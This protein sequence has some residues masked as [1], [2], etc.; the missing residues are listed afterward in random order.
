MLAAAKKTDSYARKDENLY[1][2]AQF[3]LLLG[4]RASISVSGIPL[5]TDDPLRLRG[6]VG[7]VLAGGSVDLSGN[8]LALLGSIISASGASA[9]LSCL[10][11]QL[12]LSG[13]G[14]VRRIR[15]DSA[16]GSIALQG[17]QMLY[18]AAMLSAK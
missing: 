7:T 6:M 12:G 17:G 10:P 15:V 18:S 2:D 3:T 4:E 5:L 16:G 11:N 14:G 8:I 9:E 13:T 1:A